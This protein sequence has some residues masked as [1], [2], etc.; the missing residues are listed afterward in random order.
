MKHRSQRLILFL[1]TILII[2]S[3]TCTILKPKSAA[4]Q[5]EPDKESPDSTTVEDSGDALPEATG[6]EIEIT[7]TVTY[8]DEFGYWN[9][10]GLLTNIAEYPVG[11]IA[12]DIQVAGTSVIGP[13]FIGAS[14]IAPGEIQPF[15]F[16]LPLAFTNV[17]ELE[18]NVVEIRKVLL[19]PV[20]L[21]IGQA[22]MATAENGIVT[23]IG[24][25]QN[26]AGSPARVY[27]AKAVLFSADGALIT[28]ASCQVCPGYVIPGDKAPVQFLIYGHP[29][30]AVIDHYEI[31][32]AADKAAS[33]DGLVIDFNDPVHTYTDSV[34]SFYLLGDL[35][36]NSDKILVL[37][38]LG[39]FY[40]QNREIIGAVS[41][42]LPGNSLAP[43]ESAPYELVIIDPIEAVADWSIQVDLA[44]SSVRAEPAFQLPASTTGITK[45][46]Y[47]WNV[48]GTATNDSGQSLQLIN[49]VVEVRDKGTGKLVGLNQ[50]FEA[51]DYPAGGTIDYSLNI[52]LDPAFDPS[53][54]EEFVK[55]LGE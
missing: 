43:G 45:E 41:Y 16:R 28:T 8:L 20:Q 1:V 49:V 51:G 7:Q 10:H 39:S 36:N 32:V 53:T 44:R 48:S 46:E 38:L 33:V 13:T 29:A 23:L 55:V 2:P 34:G 50:Y 4:L 19:D 27:S 15:Y 17:E 52:K 31:Y 26:N 40:N 11:S 14:G 42:G 22:K 37:R 21:E 9:L 18:V 47:L 12:V 5:R 54:L 35:Q 6:D 30:S 3:I 25:V 24:E